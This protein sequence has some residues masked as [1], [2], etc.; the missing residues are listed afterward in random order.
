MKTRGEIGFDDISAIFHYDQGIGRI[1][2]TAN[3]RVMGSNVAGRYGVLSVFGF[4]FS[5]HRVVWL[6]CTGSWPLGVIDHIDR[7]PN[8]N[9]IENL[10]DVS[11]SENTLNRDC[12][13]H[14]KLFRG[15]RRRSRRNYTASVTYEGKTYNLGSFTTAFNAKKAYEQKVEE[16]LGSDYISYGDSARFV[17][18]N[19]Y[20]EENVPTY[21]DAE[22]NPLNG[23]PPA[24]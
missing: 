6:L 15:V 21:L 17:D 24:Y 9:F 20:F 10:R 12:F 1:V 2:R 7:N 3:A 14:G 23:S 4:N 18:Y 19:S 16:L 8:N 5:Y 22:G 11:V 13:R